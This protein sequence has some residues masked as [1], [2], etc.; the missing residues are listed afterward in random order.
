MTTLYEG[1]LGGG[2]SP[3]RKIW[4][5]ERKKDK[6]SRQELYKADQQVKSCSVEAGKER[7]IWTSRVESKGEGGRGSV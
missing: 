5:E 2:R 4:K 1:C 6:N 3:K 7:T